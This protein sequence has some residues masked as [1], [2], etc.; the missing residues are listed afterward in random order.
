L[1]DT[2]TVPEAVAAELKSIVLPDWV[3]V[4][5]VPSAAI[6]HV[7]KAGLGRGETEAIYLALHLRPDRLL[8]DDGDGRREAQRLGLRVTGVLGLLV[9][10]RR[11]GLL[12]TIRPDVDRLRTAGFHVSEALYKDLLASCGEI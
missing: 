9:A 10:A 5:P 12:P 6:P 2:I 11:V 7:T 4:A 3:Q 1:F 8:L